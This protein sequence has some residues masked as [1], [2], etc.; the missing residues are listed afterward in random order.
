LAPGSLF[1]FYLSLRRHSSRSAQEE[2]PL[3][4]APPGRRVVFRSVV[5]DVEPTPSVGVDGVDLEVVCVV[6]REDDLLAI[7]RVA[8]VPVVRSVVC[9]FDPTFSA[10]VDGVDLG[11]LFVVGKGSARNRP[12]VSGSRILH[13][14]PAVNRLLTVGIRTGRIPAVARK[15]VAHGDHHRVR[16]LPALPQASR[17][18]GMTP[19]RRPRTR[20]PCGVFRSK[21]RRPLVSFALVPP[22]SRNRSIP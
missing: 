16:Y 18:R 12:Q 6:G 20:F 10:Y 8:R 15:G 19:C 17:R 11:V 9:E 22:P 21:N 3:L 14:R 4:T 13:E 1:R 2:E 5:C 7:G